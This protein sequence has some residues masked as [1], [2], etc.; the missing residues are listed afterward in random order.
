MPQL[1]RSLLEGVWL[2]NVVSAAMNQFSV[3]GAT[4]VA[5]PPL[6]V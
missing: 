6:L 5:L 3:A 2:R 4:I 1:W